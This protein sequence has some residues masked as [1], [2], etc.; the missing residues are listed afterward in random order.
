MFSY[1]KINKELWECEQARKYREAEKNAIT[2]GDS[3]DEDGGDEIEISRSV[4][5]Q[6]S[7][8]YRNINLILNHCRELRARSAQQRRNDQILGEL[9]QEG[10][11]CMGLEY[12]ESPPK[13]KTRY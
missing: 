10:G 4:S 1:K 8:E 12:P 3:E 13:K 9:D 6:V 5:K 2:I 11:S 7:E